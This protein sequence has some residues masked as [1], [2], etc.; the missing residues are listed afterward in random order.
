MKLDKKLSDGEHKVASSYAKI[1]E[2]FINYFLIVLK[3]SRTTKSMNELVSRIS[4]KGSDR[5][6]EVVELSMQ[7]CGQIL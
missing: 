3:R 5:Q 6:S 7:S 1:D 2:N 4:L